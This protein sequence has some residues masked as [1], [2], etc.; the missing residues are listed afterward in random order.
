MPLAG[1]V[2]LGVVTE[3]HTSDNTVV[4][5]LPCMRI[6]TPDAA[7][8]VVAAVAARAASLVTAVGACLCPDSAAAGNA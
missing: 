6:I 2:A 3:V 5:L 4:L 8:F 7:A 1:I